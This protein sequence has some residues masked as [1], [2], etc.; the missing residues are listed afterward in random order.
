MKAHQKRFH[1]AL[2]RLDREIHQRATTGLYSKPNA[3]RVPL[4]TLEGKAPASGHRVRT[5]AS[6]TTRKARRARPTTAERQV[7]APQEPESFRSANPRNLAAMLK[8]PKDAVLTARP[9]EVGPVLLWT[10]RNFLDFEKMEADLSSKT[11]KFHQQVVKQLPEVRASDVDHVLPID[12]F[13]CYNDA[14]EAE[15]AVK[16]RG[17]RAHGETRVWLGDE[18]FGWVGCTVLRWIEE[19]LAFEIEL[20]DRRSAFDYS[21][22]ATKEVSRFNL[23]FDG[24]DLDALERRKELA[25]QIRFEF[26][27]YVRTVTFLDSITPAPEMLDFMNPELRAK[28]P[29][30]AMTEISR[31]QKMQILRGTM[32]IESYPKLNEIIRDLGI[33]MSSYSPEKLKEP[34][35]MDT[36]YRVCLER[37]QGKPALCAELGYLRAFRGAHRASVNALESVRDYRCDFFRGKLLTVDEWMVKLKEYHQGLRHELCGYLDAIVTSI[38]N[39][40]QDVLTKCDDEALGKKTKKDSPYLVFFNKGKTDFTRLRR[41]LLMRVKQFA[42]DALADNRQF[43]E[44]FLEFSWP[45]LVV[46]EVSEENLTVMSSSITE[47]ST[48]SKQP[49]ISTTLSTTREDV[50]NLV[51]LLYSAL[52]EELAQLISPIAVLFEKTEAESVYTQDNSRFEAFVLANGLYDFVPTKLAFVSNEIDEYCKSNHEIFVAK[53][54]DHMDKAFALIPTLSC[55]AAHAV[56]FFTRESAPSVEETYEYLTLLNRNRLFFLK[57]FP[58]WIC[59]GITMLTFDD[60]RE[61]V[62][63]MTK[64]YRNSVLAAIT[65]DLIHLMDQLNDEYSK[66]GKKLRAN[67]V[68]PEQ[69][70]ALMDVLDSVPETRTKL[71]DGQ[72][73]VNYLYDLLESLFYGLTSDMLVKY[74]NVSMWPVLIDIELGKCLSLV[75]RA[76][77]I[78][79]EQISNSV[80][81]LTLQCQQLSTTIKNDTNADIKRQHAEYLAHLKERITKMGEIQERLAH[82]NY[83][84]FDGPRVRLWSLVSTCQEMVYQWENEPIEEMD[85]Y[86]IKKEIDRFLGELRGLTKSFRKDPNSLRL[87]IST[88]SDLEQL[89]PRLRICAQILSSKLKDRHKEQIIQI[90]GI[91]NYQKLTIAELKEQAGIAQKTLELAAVYKQSKSEDKTD[92]ELISCERAVHSAQVTFT[93]RRINNIPQLS[94]LIREQKGILSVIQAQ[95]DLPPLKMKAASKLM[96]NIRQIGEVLDLLGSEQAL[97]DTLAPLKNVSS[98]KEQ[99]AELKSIMESFDEQ[100]VILNK[101]PLLIAYASRQLNVFGLKSIQ[102]RLHSV[103]KE[104]IKMI[105]QMRRDV[106]RLIL[107]PDSQIINI[108]ADDLTVKTDVLSLMFPGVSKWIHDQKGQLSAVVTDT[109][110]TLKLNAP[111]SLV[112]QVVNLIPKVETSIC[113]AMKLAFFKSI[114][115]EQPFEELPLQL[116]FLRLLVDTEFVY[117]E[118]NMSFEKKYLLR[119]FRRGIVDCSDICMKA[120]VDNETV[121]ITA[122][123]TKVEYGFQMGKAV[124][125]LYS[126]H[127]Q[128]LLH[129][130]LSSYDPRR[131]LLMQSQISTISTTI[132]EKLSFLLGKSCCVIH[133]TLSTPIQQIPG[134]IQQLAS[135]SVHVCIDEIQMFSLRQM[136]EIAM[137]AQMPFF[138]SLTTNSIPTILM[139]GK[140]ICS[141]DSKQAFAHLKYI[142]ENVY[143]DQQAQHDY[144]IGTLSQYVHFYLLERY[145]ETAMHN[146]KRVFDLD[147]ITSIRMMLPPE[148]FDEAMNKFVKTD[149]ERRKRT[150]QLEKVILSTDDFVKAVDVVSD[151][152]KLGTPVMLVAGPQFSGIT[153]CIEAAAQSSRIKYVALAFASR[154][155][156]K[157]V[158]EAL[159]V[160]NSPLV[161]HILVPFDHLFFAHSSSLMLKGLICEGENSLLMLGKNT[162]VVFEMMTPI[163]SP[164]QIPIPTFTFSTPLV[165]SSELLNYW[166]VNKEMKLEYAEREFIRETVSEVVESSLQLYIFFNLFVILLQVYPNCDKDS[167]ALLIGYCIFWSRSYEM[168]TREEFEKYSSVVKS[169]IPAWSCVPGFIFEYMYKENFQ[170][171]GMFELSLITKSSLAMCNDDTILAN[172]SEYHCGAMPLTN[173][174]SIQFV[175]AVQQ[176]RPVLSDGKSCV[177]IGPA[178]SGKTTIVRYIISRYYQEPEYITLYFD[179]RNL[180]TEELYSQLLSV[181]IITIEGIIEPKNNADCI[182][183]V[184]NMPLSGQLYGAILSI[185]KTDNAIINQKVQSFKGISFLLTADSLDYQLSTCCFVTTL[186]PYSNDDYSFIA[187]ELMTRILLKRFFTTAQITQYVGQI[188]NFLPEVLRVMEENPSLCRNLHFLFRVVRSVENIGTSQITDLSNFL[189]WKM[190]NMLPLSIKT[191]ESPQQF[192]LAQAGSSQSSEKSY[193]YIPI[194]KEPQF[195]NVMFPFIHLFYFRIE[196]P[197]PALS[198]VS[199]VLDTIIM[200]SLHSVIVNDL[201]LDYEMLTQFAALAAS[202]QYVVY[203]SIQQLQSVIR[204]SICSPQPIVLFCRKPDPALIA[205]ITNG[206]VTSSLPAL[207]GCLNDNMVIEKL[208]SV[209]HTPCRFPYASLGRDI[210]GDAEEVKKTQSLRRSLRLTDSMSTFNPELSQQ[211]SVTHRVRPSDFSFLQVHMFR[212]VHIFMSVT[213]I[214]DIPEESRHIFAKWDKS[215]TMPKTESPMIQRL[216]NLMLSN[217]DKSFV[218]MM[219]QLPKVITRF[220]FLVERINKYIDQR[221]LFVQQVLVVVKAIEQAIRDTS[222]T[223][224]QTKRQLEMDQTFLATHKQAV[225]YRQNIVVELTGDLARNNAEMDVI[226]AKDAEYEA[227]KQKDSANTA[228]ALDA[229]TKV[230]VK[231]FTQEEQYKLYIQQTPSKAIRHLFNAYCILREF[232]PREDN[233]YWPEARVLLKSGRFHRTITVFDKNSIKKETVLQFDVMMNSPLI[234]PENFPQNSACRALAVWIAAVHKHTQSTSFNST[235]SQQM[236][237]LMKQKSRKEK[238]IAELEEKLKAAQDDLEKHEKSLAEL[239]EKIANETELLVNLTE[240]NDKA[241]QVSKCFPIVKEDLQAFCKGEEQYGQ[242]LQGFV[243]ATV[244]KCVVLPLF[245][246]SARPAVEKNIQELLQDSQFDSTFFVSIRDI[247]GSDDP[248]VLAILSGDRLITVFDPHDTEW[249]LLGG[250]GSLPLHSLSTYDFVYTDPSYPSFQDDIRRA[251]EGGSI[252]VIHHADKML[253]NPFLNAIASSAVTSAPFFDKI[254]NIDSDFR[255]VFLIDRPPKR[256]QPHMTFMHCAELNKAVLESIIMND[257]LPITAFKKKESASMM[258]HAQRENLYLS[259]QL[260]NSKLERIHSAE[261]AVLTDVLLQSQLLA[262]SMKQYSDSIYMD[263]HAL[264]GHE[265]VSP[266]VSNI[267]SFLEKLQD[268]YRI[269]PLYL[270]PFSKI[271]ELLEEIRGTSDFM[272]DLMELVASAMLSSHRWGI[273][274]LAKAT[275]RPVAPKKLNIFHFQDIACAA[276]YLLNA[277]SRKQHHYSIE[278]EQTLDIEDI[279]KNL[280]DGSD[281]VISF[282][283]ENCVCA[284]LIDEFIAG[285]P[286]DQ[287]HSDSRLFL[288]TDTSFEF[289]AHLVNICRVFALE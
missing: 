282:F 140:N 215:D 273:D 121:F 241:Q 64:A 17:E 156:I 39:N 257:E 180:T 47:Q 1:E 86:H 202:A 37:I 70:S 214:D 151:Q 211:Q 42:I 141:V 288:L 229:A 49:Y 242:N 18:D 114:R 275:P 16:Q 77:T 153:T 124:S 59:F 187:R 182:V 218:K 53:L 225:E 72:R 34:L 173:I 83:D 227:Y 247:I 116:C 210:S 205:Y 250:E 260:L 117:D 19:S 103:Q 107:I 230:V 168:K 203:H 159:A 57:S 7:H 183:V 108:F 184:D 259:L 142:L 244:A 278:Y 136:F 6:P 3:S 50:D 66:L 280:E 277:N 238:E 274:D 35:V 38:E 192:E 179:G 127:T 95:T 48:T 158:T 243:L 200:P 209:K 76:G 145:I 252:A 197:A 176:F 75:E 92:L 177:L 101:Q 212:N 29:E 194:D 132:F 102:E 91:E 161:L 8:I 206:L 256:I 23:R 146:E 169:K 65:E 269:S 263:S 171:E 105:A 160:D 236:L 163:T 80:V 22:M 13:D 60:L 190:R 67:V 245:P 135:R 44:E 219:H 223:I 289:P 122:G 199:F 285:F 166:M 79:K 129:K 21:K 40:L 112:D 150:L 143:P 195:E 246:S 33:D 175:N 258:L 240:F 284:E 217:A 139:C 239:Q 233:D 253:S 11:F 196:L 27:R 51:T 235:V 272:R 31:T 58:K 248:L 130:M 172:Y 154:N 26:E 62:D 43:F 115:S 276:E 89:L 162:R 201:N 56:S 99:V 118:S 100:M 46:K 193:Y 74:L 88:K 270:W 45:E 84:K 251:A 157:L 10:D 220:D 110:D 14:P 174:P 137:L 69:W 119:V 271:R 255:V 123:T 12:Y 125:Y 98:M 111:V 82:A 24:E 90:L 204:D 208:D 120:H 221:H 286:V 164:I 133:P 226:K 2:K 232:T 287:W 4:K 152:F 126:D 224:E 104:F 185:I 55:H 266:I 128:K 30:D 268:L 63:A 149:D 96:Q 85:F 61:K 147:F 52:A 281:V 155:W 167:L 283:C 87:L 113:Q 54:R 36:K 170:K 213:S 148:V 71:E 189:F 254:T 181:S 28:L 261:A 106:P 109:N 178:G 198:Y 267:I 5:P 9:Q 264:D 93:N 279:R 32:Q 138:C 144:L 216:F 134:I 188:P 94:E 265:W 228:A 78:F 165:K 97:L 207:F 73:R 15:I 234:K 25:E 131:P 68:N 249:E 41:V 231:A 222:S 262:T 81:Q 20:D 237:E 191:P 186:V